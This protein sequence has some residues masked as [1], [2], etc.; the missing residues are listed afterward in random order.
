MSSFDNFAKEIEKEMLNEVKK[1]VREKLGTI[2]HPET[3]EFPT[4]TI[5]GD[6]LEN[7]KVSIEGSPELLQLVNERLEQDDNFED[8]KDYVGQTMNNNSPNVF[9]S[10]ASEDKDIAGKIAK[11][12]QEN[13]IETWW[14]GWCIRAGDSIR[15]KIDEGIEGCTDFIV[16]LSPD[17]ITKPW[18]NQEIDAGFVRKLNA[19][20][21]FIPVRVNLPTSELSPLLLGITS[22]EI[23]DF[24]KDVTKLINDIYGIS[25]KPPLG[26]SPGIVEEARE[27][28]TSYS[29]AATTIAKIFVEKSKTARSGDPSFRIQELQELTKLS[30]E[31]IED[32]LYELSGM[33]D[34]SHGSVFPKDEIYASFDKYWKDWD[35]AED[36]LKIAADLVNDENFP[37][38]V[39]Q[40]A[41]RYG[42]EPRRMNSALA[43]LINR[44]IL[45]GKQV[46][47]CASWITPSL[48][49]T[50][51]T[52]RFVKSRQ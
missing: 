10:Y 14:D 21:N 48:D 29:A 35:S 36:G 16:L 13:G 43:Y 15:Q 46:L 31:D 30:E 19:Q 28:N 3:G 51:E 17:S 11:K 45:R 32:A 25:I 39:Q 52:R 24:E 7:M 47:T 42:W 49:K 41:E 20:C 2:R 5:L 37:S 38:S 12:L 9:L 22:P 44:N 50:A 33:V 27:K 18:V 4:V 40:I 8:I 23:N 6:D 1:L 34:V 26:S